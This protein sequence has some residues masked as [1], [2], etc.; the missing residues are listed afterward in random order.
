MDTPLLSESSES[1]ESSEQSDEN[2]CQGQ[3]RPGTEYA[4]DKKEASISRIHR[5]I[6]DV[7]RHDVKEIYMKEFSKQ[8][9][10][11]EYLKRYFERF[12]LLERFKDE[13]VLPHDVLQ[14]ILGNQEC[15]EAARELNRLA[16][17]KY[18]E[19]KELQNVYETKKINKQQ[20]TVKRF[21]GTSIKFGRVR[22]YQQMVLNFTPCFY[23]TMFKFSEAILKMETELQQELSSG[24]TKQL[25]DSDS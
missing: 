18:T 20:I 17:E 7:Y 4:V 16:K 15:L 11:R 3:H 10:L 22:R 14:Q 12:G 8:I 9:H 5:F 23:L 21:M 13:T 2:Y 19:L 24:K 6:N 1:S 25:F